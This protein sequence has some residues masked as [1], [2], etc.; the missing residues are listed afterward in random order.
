MTELSDFQLLRSLRSLRTKAPPSL[1]EKALAA[2]GLVDSYAPM[3]SAIGPMWVAWGADGITAVVPADDDE[4][5][6]VAGYDRPLRRVDSVP[7]ALL[8][9]PTFDLRGLTEFE[10]SVLE[11]ARRIPV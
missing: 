4:E 3:P 7:P 5:S 6:F 8:R 2:V 9:R 10:R 11:T 1:A